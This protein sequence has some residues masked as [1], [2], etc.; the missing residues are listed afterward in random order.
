VVNSRD[1]G[2]RG[3]RYIAN[4]LKNYGYDARRGQQFSGANGDADVVGLPYIHIESKFVEALNVGKA[5]EQACADA[6]TEEMPTVMHKKN[7]KPVLV[8]LG[9]SDFMK[10]YQGWMLSVARGDDDESET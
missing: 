4:L 10:L 7:N 6:R 9:F 5:Y 1:K 8:T 2:A 3:E